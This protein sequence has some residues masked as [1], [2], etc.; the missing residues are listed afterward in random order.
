V[1]VSLFVR[2]ILINQAYRANCITVTRM[3]LELD[4]YCPFV[5]D[6]GQQ[7]GFQLLLAKFYY[8]KPLNDRQVPVDVAVTAWLR[9]LRVVSTLSKRIIPLSQ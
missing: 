3:K 2:S 9:A 1:S 7:N 4:P 8:R 5:N 6:W